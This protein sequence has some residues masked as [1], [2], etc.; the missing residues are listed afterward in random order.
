MAA[1]E[2]PESVRLDLQ[3]EQ[4]LP[5]VE[6]VPAEELV[7]P[8]E[9]VEQRRVVRVREPGVQEQDRLDDLLGDDADHVVLHEVENEDFALV[10]AHDQVLRVQDFDPDDRVV[11]VLAQE[12]VVD[13]KRPQTERQHALVR[14]QKHLL[15]VHARLPGFPLH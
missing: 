9:T 8:V 4:G 12:Q 5:V 15:V 2:R 13:R 3:L 14:R 7:A 10:R 11:L 1:Q 6:V